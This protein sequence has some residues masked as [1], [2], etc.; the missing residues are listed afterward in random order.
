[1]TAEPA[2]A[3][4]GR[5]SPSRRWAAWLA[6]AVLAAL[7]RGLYPTADPPWRATVG[8]VWH[9]EGAWTH[10][11]RNRALWGTWRTDD[12]NPLYVAPV[13]TG[14]EYAAFAT[15][16]VGTWQARLVPMTLGVIA[17]VALG[18]GVARI[19][20]RRAGIAAGVLLATN[21]VGAMYDR[22]AIMEG[23]MAAAIVVSWWAFAKA[24]ERP[25]WGAVAGVAAIAAYFVKAAAVFFV[26]A[27]GL[28]ALVAIALPVRSAGER[29]GDRGRAAGLWTLAGLAVAGI[30][31]LAL[32]VGPEWSEYRFYNWQMSVTRKPSYDAQSL[33]NRVSW[34]P[35]LHDV[36]SRMWVVVALGLAAFVA[37]ALDWFRR[38]PA[39]QLLVLWVGVGRPR[40]AAARRRQRAPIRVPDPGVHGAGRTGDRLRSRHRAGLAGTA[41][42]LAAPA[43]RAAGALR[44]LRRVGIAGP[45][46]LSLRRAPGG[47]GRG[48][49]WRWPRPP[50]PGS[51][52]S[53]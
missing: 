6:I 2:S 7:L 12:W 45:P 44:R 27:I 33:L 29:A 1:M 25:A 41:A 38:P 28:T 42:R 10:N 9:D 40:A 17:V 21:Y 31:A 14:L 30:V 53:G 35:V 32:F 34:F 49:C 26:G 19:G 13:F 11:A 3:A 50:R 39:E 52:G 15:F 43:L 4:P 5:Q 36:L 46:R 22:A 16:G 47:P 8:V 51:S 18:C 20:G 23:P 48:R 24:Q 37:R